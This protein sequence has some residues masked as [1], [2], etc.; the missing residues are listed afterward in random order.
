MRITHSIPGLTLVAALFLANGCG[1]EQP[2]A[3]ETPKAMNP[4]PAEAQRPAAEPA[5]A[6]PT[7][8]AAPAQPPSPAASSAKPTVEAPKAATEQPPPAAVPA[9][10][11]AVQSAATQAVATA[12]AAAASSA[13][14]TQVQALI[15][16]AKGLLSDQKYQDALNTVQQLSN[17]KLTPEQQTLVDSLK[18]QIQSA[19]AK[20]ATSNAASALGNI[21]GGTK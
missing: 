18:A 13:A 12:A 21:L 8:T 9:P 5:P 14:G 16:K 2:P 7:P 10:A 11:Q 3:G 1:K 4:A 20:S 17:L 15:D 19:M 6:T